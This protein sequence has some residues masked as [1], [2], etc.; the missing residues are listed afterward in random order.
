MA[1]I[2]RL[3]SWIFYLQ[4]KRVKL[5]T[6]TN[7]HLWSCSRN[8][9]LNHWFLLLLSVTSL[10][11]WLTRV[12]IYVSALLMLFAKHFLIPG[13]RTS[14]QL[15]LVRLS[16]TNENHIFLGQFFYRWLTL[17]IWWSFHKENMYL[18][19]RFSLTE[20]RLSFLF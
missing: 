12:F 2:P 11:C 15:S 6:I 3:L 20:R 13:K 5:I 7:P 18:G 4:K 9:Y 10:T 17:R 1:A 8:F 19:Y 14:W 16:K